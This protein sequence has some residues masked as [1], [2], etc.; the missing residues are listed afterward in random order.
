MPLQFG[1]E[2]VGR[3]APLAQ[4]DERLDDLGAFRVGLADHGDLGDGRVLDDDAFDIK[5][6]DAIADRSYDVVVAADEKE[7]AVGVLMHDVAGQI[8]VAAQAR[9]LGLEIAVGR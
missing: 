2:R 1:G 6:A 3:L 9:R 4:H 8:P 7:M 5:G